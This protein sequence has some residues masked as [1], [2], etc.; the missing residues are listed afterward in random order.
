[1]PEAVNAHQRK[2]TLDRVI[3]GKADQPSPKPFV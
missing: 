3:A 1:M 2:G